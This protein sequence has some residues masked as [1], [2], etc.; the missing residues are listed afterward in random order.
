[1]FI[2]VVAGNLSA[3][4]IIIGSQGEAGRKSR[5]WNN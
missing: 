2:S 4:L 1:M 3:I 5:M